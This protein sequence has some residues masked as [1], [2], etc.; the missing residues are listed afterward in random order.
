MADRL[1]IDAATLFDDVD[2]RTVEFSGEID[3]ERYDFALQYDVIEALDGSAPDD[4]AIMA[5]E[6]HRDAIEKA[7]TTA[8]ARDPDQDRVVV[9]ENDLD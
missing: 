2:A 6:R 3:G 4:G 1:S 9:S 8:L 5:F 7:A